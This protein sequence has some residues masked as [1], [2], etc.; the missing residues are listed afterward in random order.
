VAIS[1]PG[2]VKEEPT[3]ESWAPPYISQ[4]MWLR[5]IDEM[6]LGVKG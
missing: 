2:I 6:L 5:L 4:P 3:Q 1:P